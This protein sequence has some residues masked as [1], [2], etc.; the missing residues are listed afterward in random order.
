MRRTMR[1]A[2]ASLYVTAGF[3]HLRWPD[4]FLPI[5][6]S[7]VP[8]PRDVI[9]VTGVCELAGGTA[10]LTR[11]LRWL[12]GVM[13][14]AYAACVFPANIKH[15]IEGIQVAGLPTSWW[16]HG[17]RLALQP[18]L[19]WWALFCAEVIDWPFS[20][21]NNLTSRQLSSRSS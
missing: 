10:L 16:Y 20:K 15:A 14:A 4:A 11:H 17:P 21:Q 13:L 18:F 8:E 7:W 6:P 9:L 5:V 3:F 1:F 12:A 19:V 2:M